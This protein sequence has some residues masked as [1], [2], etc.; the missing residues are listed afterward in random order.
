MRASRSRTRVCVCVRARARTSAASPVGE[1][2]ERGLFSSCSGLR[3]ETPKPLADKPPTPPL[4]NT[5][6]VYGVIPAAPRA[7]AHARSE[8]AAWYHPVTG[9][10]GPLLPV[11]AGAAAENV[12][13]SQSASHACAHRGG[14]G[15]ERH[16]SLQPVREPDRRVGEVAHAVH[17]A[18]Q[19]VGLL[20]A[21]GLAVGGQR[22]DVGQHV[23]AQVLVRALQQVAGGH[24]GRRQ[25][26]QGRRLGRRILEGLR[27]RAR[28]RGTGG[29]L[30]SRGAEARW[31]GG[32]VA[33]WLGGWAAH[34]LGSG[35]ACRGAATSSPPAARTHARSTHSRSV[36]TVGEDAYRQS[37]RAVA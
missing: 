29:Q 16:V 21:A 5:A 3:V 27:A 33:G 31:R 4:E 8:S 24:T 17:V 12:G 9:E 6:C 14:G 23:D 26:T 34:L 7:H 1:L 18:G 10:R 36:R 2:G 20:G 30:S 37:G 11:P 35:G 32:W 22:V 15:G 13:E 19:A 28:G 25:P